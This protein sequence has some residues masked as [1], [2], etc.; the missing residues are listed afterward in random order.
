MAIINWCNNNPGFTS[1]AL[2]VA[3]VLVSLYALFTS[4]RLQKKIHNRDVKMAFQNKVLEI[5]NIFNECLRI[6]DNEDVLLIS[7]AG[8]WE[9][10]IEYKTKVIE[11]RKIIKRT[12]DEVHLIFVNDQPLKCMLVEMFC[13]FMPLSERH[14]EL[15]QQA[16]NRTPEV[17][18]TISKVYPE[19][20]IDSLSDLQKIYTH[21]QAFILFEALSTTPESKKFDADLKMFYKKF[22]V[23][24]FD[25]RFEKHLLLEKL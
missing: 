12:L 21:P 3:S 15:I 10:F 6:L 5:Y 18:K 23:E 19:I 14:I 22:S 17:I 24:N 2:A 9:K 25:K 16:Q 20:Q 7:K 8:C 4:M 11:H 1:A 13:D